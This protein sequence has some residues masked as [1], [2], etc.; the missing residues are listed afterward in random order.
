M[1]AVVHS[2]FI[3]PAGV[4][5]VTEVPLS[6][7]LETVGRF[8]KPDYY[9]RDF[10]DIGLYLMIDAKAGRLPS[11]MDFSVIEALYH[12][13]S[14]RRLREVLQYMNEEGVPVPS[15]VRQ[16]VLNHLNP[17]FDVS[18]RTEYYDGIRFLLLTG[19]WRDKRGRASEP[20]KERPG[21]REAK[22]IRTLVEGEL[23]GFAEGLGWKPAVLKDVVREC[24]SQGTEV[25]VLSDFL[26]ALSEYGW[27]PFATAAIALKAVRKGDQLSN[28]TETLQ[29]LRDLDWDD[30]EKWEAVM[31]AVGRLE[32]SDWGSFP[33]FLKSSE[34]FEGRLPEKVEFFR[35]MSKRPPIL[36]AALVESKSG[37][38]NK[39]LFPLTAFR[40]AVEGLSE[41]ELPDS[42]IATIL[43]LLFKSPAD[44][45]QVLGWLENLPALTALVKRER[46]DPV[47]GKNLFA[48][49]FYKYPHAYGNYEGAFQTALRELSPRRRRARRRGPIEEII[50]G[51]TRL[52]FG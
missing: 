28:L 48:S 19:T 7:A 10:E 33:G 26:R 21:R 30:Q 18:T 38:W 25:P 16:S 27:P 13:G 1:Q 32:P 51:L 47:T 29:G 41:Q 52:L 46:L 24:L 6:V 3:P 22:R 35:L 36:E 20:V 8:Y 50:Y 43:T 5:D 14:L 44:T 34:R 49:C 15:F 42:E 37:R 39:C 17:D 40:A 31:V 11:G 2:L 4:C 12:E 9:E 23:A 45:D